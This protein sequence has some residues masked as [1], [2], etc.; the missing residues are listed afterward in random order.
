MTSTS[1]SI[2][3]DE[4]LGFDPAHLGLRFTLAITLP[5][6]RDASE[7]DIARV[8][9]PAVEPWGMPYHASEAE[10]SASLTKLR[11]RLKRRIREGHWTS[12]RASLRQHSSALASFP[13]AS[14]KH[15]L[16]SPHGALDPDIDAALRSALASVPARAAEATKRL[17]GLGA[18][19]L[20]GEHGQAAP[21]AQWTRMMQAVIEHS[22]ALLA[23]DAPRD[24]KI[25]VDVVPAEA[26]G[27]ATG[28]DLAPF[29]QQLQSSRLVTTIDTTLNPPVVQAARSA[30]IQ[31]ADIAVRELT[32]RGRRSGPRLCRPDQLRRPERWTITML[33][34]Q[35]PTPLRPHCTSDAAP[36]SPPSPRR[37]H[38][39]ALLDGREHELPPIL[40]PCFNA[41]GA[42]QTHE[43]L[44]DALASPSDIPRIQASL[45][46]ALDRKWCIRDT[47]GSP[48]PGFPFDRTLPFAYQ[49]TLPLLDELARRAASAQN[50]GSGT[51]D[52]SGGGHPSTDSHIPSTTRSQSTSSQGPEAAN[53]AHSQAWKDIETMGAP[54][55]E[56]SLPHLSVLPVETVHP[57][58]LLS[59]E[60]AALLEGRDPYLWTVAIGRLLRF[61][62]HAQ[63]AR[64][65]GR[66]CR[67][68]RPVEAARIAGDGCALLIQ[69]IRDL[70][71]VL[72]G[73]EGP[74]NAAWALLSARDDLESARLA[75]Q[76]IERELR[77]DDTPDLAEELEF[78]LAEFGGA[79]P[80]LD[81]EIAGLDAEILE[82]L[83]RWPEDPHRLRL[84]A[85]ELPGAS[86]APSE[87]FRTVLD[88][89][90]V[91]TYQLASS[92]TLESATFVTDDLASAH[93]SP[94]S[95]FVAADIA[96][97]V[98]PSRYRPDEVAHVWL[99]DC[100]RRMELPVRPSPKAPR[101]LLGPSQPAPPET[102]P[103]A[104]VGAE[105]P[106]ETRA[107]LRA[108]RRT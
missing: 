8:V 104:E 107:W 89:L 46:D 45:R 63:F 59:V 37:W 95:W 73:A 36:S 85:L 84:D 33:Y 49:T 98:P 101:V 3:T 43:A 86:A 65:V 35:I 69:E 50:N 78:Q 7:R 83:V 82:G 71:A 5:G 19:V 62:G 56:V 15:Y 105:L 68:V 28:F 30:G 2:F 79:L 100:H 74:P 41:C 64:E 21:R 96:V 27:H 93:R 70:A 60:R 75:L 61:R 97:V 23:L 48:P 24:S 1:F 54:I 16:E 99:V 44:R 87:A 55:L 17:L 11:L 10:H 26:G 88:R 94:E 32:R 53:S 25:S 91:L 14:L 47:S 58:L 34:D 18:Y 103:S 20:C 92:D 72:R 51:P 77:R 66:A 90:V 22:L 76:Q 106:A 52:T 108:R 39:P 80:A 40:D 38:T 31:L 9:G 57:S 6:R 12:V 42:L 4:T 102:P 29:V 81:A 13:D 67:A